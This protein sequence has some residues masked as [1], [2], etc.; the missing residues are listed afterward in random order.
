VKPS[1][2]GLHEQDIYCGALLDQNQWVAIGTNMEY[3]KLVS[4]SLNELAP[5]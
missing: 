3:H 5:S 2:S 4:I 1:L